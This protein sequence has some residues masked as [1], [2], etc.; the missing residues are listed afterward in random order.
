MIYDILNEEV[1]KFGIP[2]EPDV[3]MVKYKQRTVKSSTHP[4]KTFWNSIYMVKGKPYR[5]RVETLIFNKE[6]KV[7]LVKK[8]KP[9]KYGVMYSLP[10]GSTEPGTLPSKQAELECLEEARIITKNIQYTG[11]TYQ[12]T[13]EPY[14]NPYKNPKNEIEEQK[15]KDYF[16]YY[17]YIVYI[18][19]AE[20]GGKYRGEIDPFDEDKKFANAC[21]FY[22]INEINW[23]PEH[24]EA[25]KFYN[26]KIFDTPEKFNKY[27]NTFDYGYYEDGKNILQQDDFKNYKTISIDDF[28]FHKCGVCWDYVEYEAY[29]FQKY[30]G[31]KFTTNPLTENNTFCMYYMQH[32]DENKNMPSHTWLA[33]NLNNQIY[34]FE[35]SW[36]S[37]QGIKKFNS[38]YEMIIEYD[39]RQREYYHKNNN[40]LTESLFVKYAPA[41]K[42]NLT[43]D[44]YMNNIYDNKRHVVV[45]SDFKEFPVKQQ[46]NPHLYFYHLLPKNIKLT[47][48]G[49]V[50]LQFMYDNK[51]YKEFDY[52]TDKYRDRLVNAWG[53]YPDK[54][55]KKLTREE[56]IDGL[57]KFR[58]ENGLNAIYFFRYPPYKKLGPRM[59]DILN[60]K[61]IY[62]IDL[63]DPEVQKY[64]QLIDWGY[65]NS[66]SNNKKLNREYYEQISSNQYFK[67]YNDSVKINFA[68]LNH[69][70]I[71]PLYNYI[72]AHLLEKI[73]T[74]NSINDLYNNNLNES[75]IFTESIFHPKITLYHGSTQLF[76]E[77]L[78]TAFSA[79]NKYFSKPS[80]AVFMFKQFESARIYSCSKALSIHFKNYF[81]P[82]ADEKIKKISY[83][84]HDGLFNYKAHSFIREDI[85]KK[86]YEDLKNMD[87]ET[88][89]YELEVPIDKNLSVIGTSPIL[90][91]FTYTGKVKTKKVHVIKIT[92]ELFTEIYKPISKTEYAKWVKKN[93]DKI[94]K[95]L[96]LYGP[97]GEILYHTDERKRMREIIEEKLKNGEI[98][99]GDDLSFLYDNNIGN[100]NDTNDK[101][102]NN[103][104]KINNTKK[105]K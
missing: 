97:F 46:L 35:S 31:F 84:T 1:N 87:I 59:E 3:S 41:N 18:F 49:L 23:R 16:M 36:R 88:Y 9:T 17:G 12:G 47:K 96:N 5:V 93:K 94:Y 91:E 76:K 70:S 15:K 8:D 78:P 43:P 73:P 57:K 4:D 37:Y 30:L 98:K 24:V 103:N 50:S 13:V 104:K 14:P 71:I 56:I 42:F 61:N 95:S 102:E 105:I 10:G 79:G 81:R 66:H 34:A 83:F 69:I 51:M 44:E 99:P 75:Y 58:G 101:N 33:Y 45:K 27:L 52:Y 82:N 72:P 39:K 11:L 65:E 38:E 77:I 2:K 19:V 90:P 48:Y 86:I 28:I 20:Y 25:I 100:D 55:P 64:I 80:W 40:F 22:G 32:M 68:A 74:P 53:Y 67:K 7:L 60:H 29:Y 26:E 54:N 21:D 89:V 85:Y 6:G 63:N 92:P 62:R